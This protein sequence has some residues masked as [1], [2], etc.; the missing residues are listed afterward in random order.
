MTNEETIRNRMEDLS[1][2]ARS[3][4]V[5]YYRDARAAGGGGWHWGPSMRWRRESRGRW[6]RDGTSANGIPIK[7]RREIQS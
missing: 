1:R 6:A 7:T 5:A 4:L 2:A 3:P